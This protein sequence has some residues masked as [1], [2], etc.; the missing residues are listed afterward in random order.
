MT[1]SLNRQIAAIEYMVSILDGRKTR[2]KPSVL[3]EI[4]SDAAEGIRTLHRVELDGNR[5]R[6]D[7]NAVGAR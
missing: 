7:A 3:T 5:S 2:P 4:L 6:S 1:P